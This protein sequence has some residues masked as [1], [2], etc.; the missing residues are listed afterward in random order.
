MMVPCTLSPMPNQSPPSAA[1]A[2]T[3][4]AT[5]SELVYEMPDAEPLAYHAGVATAAAATTA[6]AAAAVEYLEPLVVGADYENGCRGS[7]NVRRCCCQSNTRCEPAPVAH[8]TCPTLTN[9]GASVLG[10]HMMHAPA[11][12]PACTHMH[13]HTHTHTGCSGLVKPAVG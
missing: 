3:A 9:N 10:T 13:T 6:A 2:D 8:P 5:V 4:A 12:A 1:A 7:T 11:P